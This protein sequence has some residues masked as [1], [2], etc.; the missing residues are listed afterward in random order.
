MKYGGFITN[1]KE[2]KKSFI[3]KSY[4]NIGVSIL[5]NKNIINTINYLDSI[6]FCINNNVLNYIFNLLLNNN[7]NIL[8]LIKL[9]LHHNTNNLYLLKYNKNMN[10]FNTILEHNSQ[11][12]NDNNVMQISLLLSEWCNENDNNSFYFNHYVD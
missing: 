7:K 10:E 3:R 11:F 8:N 2:D 5:Y 9:N 4:K 12:Y 1:N 6:K